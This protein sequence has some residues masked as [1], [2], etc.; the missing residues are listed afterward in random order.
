MCHSILPLWLASAQGNPA[1][2]HG[3]S[4]GPG[5]PGRN[6]GTKHGERDRGA[7]FE[8]REG[9]ANKFVS[10]LPRLS[11][12]L[13]LMFLF[14][15]VVWVTAMGWLDSVVFQAFFMIFEC[16]CFSVLLDF[17]NLC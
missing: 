10:R 14:Q 15:S 2:L 6:K 9:F 12:A 5:R 4:Q 13:L 11:L 17:S 7:D 1:H 8:S 16:I 3:V